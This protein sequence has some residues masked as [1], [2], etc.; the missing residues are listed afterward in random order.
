MMLFVLS[1][2]GSLSRVH[3]LHHK[4]MGLRTGR[5]TLFMSSTIAPK[6]PMDFQSNFNIEEFETVEN[7]LSGVNM[8]PQDNYVTFQEKEHVYSF[9]GEPMSLSVTSLIGRYFEKFDADKIADKMISGR[10][11]PR[12]EYLH[13]DG[14]PFTKQEIMDQWDSVGEIARN[15]GTWMHYNI[16]RFL[17]DMAPALDIPE[18]QHFMAFHKEVL[19]NKQCK[20]F[21]TEWRIA[22]PDL[23]LA[24]SVDLVLE[25][26]DG[27]YVLLD[28]KRSKKVP[29]E[30]SASKAYGKFGG[31]PLT[32]IPDCDAAKYFLQL[33]MY[34]HILMEYYDI[35]VSDMLL[36][37]LHPT[38][39][40]Y[41]M[42]KVPVMEK[43]TLLII[44]HL[45]SGL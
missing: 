27:S 14:N 19:Q 37:S 9:K 29:F 45:R 2:F 4:S 7:K 3:G 8:H 33:N 31:R 38:L 43:E 20:P 36:V 5:R 41:V 28:W 25:N 40:S 15:R 39:P 1:V 26:S 6:E 16:E 13:E 32:H 12:R 22:A 17:N 44:D 24:G 35:R 34:R 23:S 11:W 10:N 21:R 30:M 18:M 42:K